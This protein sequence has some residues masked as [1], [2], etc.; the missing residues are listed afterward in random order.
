[1]LVGKG[2]NQATVIVHKKVLCNASPFFEAACKPEWMK[3]EDKGIKMPEDDPEAIN[4]MVWWMYRNEL[5]IT[6][7]VMNRE[8]GRTTQGAMQSIW[9]LCAKLYVLGQKYQM[10]R[11]QVDAI[12]GILA[13]NEN[14]EFSAGIIP[15]VYEN[16]T[17]KSDSLRK[18]LVQIARSYLTAE[19]LNDF[20]SKFGAEFLFEIAHVFVGDRDGAGGE[21]A[22]F[23]LCEEDGEFCEQLHVEGGCDGQCTDFKRFVV[24][25]ES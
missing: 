9:G 2:D 20:R 6:E 15:W 14:E 17:D 19:Q 24:E 12:D 13:L 8:L 1:L 3:A 25:D 7:E 11:L 4:I 21:Y 10:P 23:S 16:T 22:F 5:C 18:V